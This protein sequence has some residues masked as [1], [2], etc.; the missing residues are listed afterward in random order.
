MMLTWLTVNMSLTPVS[1][2]VKPV[3][4][5]EAHLDLRGK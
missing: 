5:T 4:T 3:N 1:Y 2:G